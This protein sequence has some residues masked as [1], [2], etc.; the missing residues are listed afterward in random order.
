MLVLGLR[1]NEPICE[2]SS[3]DFLPLRPRS[4]QSAVAGRRFSSSVSPEKHALTDPEALTS[5]EESEDDDEDNDEELLRCDRS[6]MEEG[7]TQAGLVDHDTEVASMN[8]R[9]PPALLLRRRRRRRAVRRR[10]QQTDCDIRQSAALKK[11]VARFRRCCCCC[12]RSGWAAADGAAAAGSTQGICQSG[13][14]SMSANLVDCYVL[15]V[16]RG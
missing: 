10:G 6:Q 12:R 3:A 14:S 8:S 2:I 7:E 5:P 11:E 15:S 13:N 16:A 1:D 4:A 9:R